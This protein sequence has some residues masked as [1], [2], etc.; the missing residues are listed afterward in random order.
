MCIEAG[1]PRGVWH[2]GRDHSMRRPR[3]ALLAPRRCSHSGEGSFHGLD[4]APSKGSSTSKKP[5]KPKPEP[6]SA[7]RCRRGEMGLDS[8]RSHRSNG[9]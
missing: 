9:A 6:R 1:G 5:L 8:L 7:Q 3:E 2:D 4:R